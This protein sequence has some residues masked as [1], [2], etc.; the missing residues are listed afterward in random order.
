MKR[1]NAIVMIV[2][3]TVILVLSFT[4]C[5]TTQTKAENASDQVGS[6]AVDEATDAVE[7]NV[8]E[9]VRKGI[10]DAFKGILGK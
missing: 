7:D 3:I 6:G 5:P 4:G 8:R 1:F 2:L 10:N 9:G